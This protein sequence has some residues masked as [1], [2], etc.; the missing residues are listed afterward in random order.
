MTECAK[1]NRELINSMLIRFTCNVPAPGLQRADG[2]FQS[3]MQYWLSM[4]FDV[5]P[6]RPRIEETSDVR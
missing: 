5:A 1:V 2:F 6:S 4:I 3:M